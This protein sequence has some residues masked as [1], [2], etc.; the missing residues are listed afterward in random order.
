MEKKET[1]ICKK[2]QEEINKKAKKCPKCGAKQGFPKWIIVIVAIILIGIIA[3]SDGN[4]AEETKNNA[5]SSKSTP[6]FSY[7]ITS[8]YND[9]FTHYVEGTVKNNKNRDYSY[10]QIEFIC[11][12]ADGNNIGTA[13]DNTNN[14]LANQTWKFKAMGLFT[15]AD[16]DHCDFHEVK[17]W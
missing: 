13:V 14:L 10:V 1:K 9:T 7:E 8:E 16:A 12:D 11:Y 5:K 17:G 3:S 6:K 2:C 4:D 15:D